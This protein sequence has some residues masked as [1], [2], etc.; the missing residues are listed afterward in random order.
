M[1]PAL[2]TNDPKNS[3]STGGGLGRKLRFAAVRGILQACICVNSSG[4]IVQPSLLHRELLYDDLT[5]HVKCCVCRRKTWG[6]QRMGRA[7]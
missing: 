6:A 4:S 2:P 3:W 1:A 5:D 7:S